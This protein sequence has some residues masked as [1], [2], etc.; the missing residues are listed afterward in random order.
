MAR[1]NNDPHTS[2]NVLHRLGMVSA[3]TL[4]VWGTWVAGCSTEAPQAQPAAEEDVQQSHQSIE[5]SD[6]DEAGTSVPSQAALSDITAFFDVGAGVQDLASTDAIGI[7][8]ANHADRTIPVEIRLHLRG[9][10]AKR[11]LELARITLDARESRVLSWS[12]KESPIIPVGTS[13]SALVYASYEIDGAKLEIP[14]QPLTFAFDA[15]VSRVFVSGEDD[16]GV[17]LASAGRNVVSRTP[18]SAVS[19]PDRSLVLATLGSRHGWLDGNAV[20]QSAREV[21]RKIPDTLVDT[22]EG[23]VAAFPGTLDDLQAAYS[24]EAAPQKGAVDATTL[25]GP[26]LTACLLSQHVNTKTGKYCANWQPQGFRD[27][28]V[29]STVVAED[30]TGSGPAAYAQAV[31]MSGSTT[32][33]QGRLDTSGCT[34]TIEFCNNV[35]SLSVSTSSIQIPNQTVGTTLTYGT[36]EFKIDPPMTYAVSPS[37]RYSLALPPYDSRIIF[38]VTQATPTVRVASIVSRILTMSDN[39][40]KRNGFLVWAPQLLIKTDQGCMSSFNNPPYPSNFAYI[41]PVTGQTKYGEACAGADNASFGQT[42]AIQQDGQGNYYYVPTAWHTTQDAVTIGHELGHSAQF[43][44]NGGPGNAGYDDKPDA[45][46]C[47][48]DWVSDGNRTHCLQSRHRMASAESEGFGHFYAARV[49]N[50]YGA[51]LDARF[52]YYKN[53]RKKLAGGANQDF[54]P[55]YPISI[56][57]PYNGQGWVKSQC[58]L[59]DKSSEY[60]WLTFFWAV[61][62]KAPSSSRSAMAD[63]FAIL[64]GAASNFTWANVT[65]Q[66]NLRYGDP[67]DP[68]A[69]HLALSGQS[70]GLNL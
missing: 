39:G 2:R 60:D 46:D 24:S 63:L 32:V 6:S 42:L 55:P 65:A 45:G 9:L 53:Y 38:N 8:I 5:R 61:N 44:M 19:T 54:A 30:F 67:S 25:D 56:G 41:D 16:V 15:S 33:W 64:N 34:P 35:E 40:V 58:S 31:A 47:S 68:R 4:L 51:G 21:A 69:A 26:I 37:L 1:R 59:T 10:G 50:D 12:P 13:A 22:E 14:S 29:S 62:G 3:G 70:H 48:C 17:R 66:A 11:T 18:R 23:D 43:S 20:E 57:A 36:R 7:T 27:V 49:M 52:T 28:A